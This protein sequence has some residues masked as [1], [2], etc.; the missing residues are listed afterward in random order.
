MVWREASRA[1]ANSLRN[2]GRYSLRTRAALA[3]LMHYPPELTL[4][5]SSL[6]IPKARLMF[7]WE[8]A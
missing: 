6:R 8:L 3:G 4:G 5:S 7:S 1:P 2:A